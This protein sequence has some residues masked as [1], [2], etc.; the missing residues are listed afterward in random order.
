MIYKLGDLYSASNLPSPVYWA[1]ARYAQA[2][3]TYI[4]ENGFDCVICT[5]LY[6][7]EAMTAIR[8]DPDF[9]V[10]AYGV[11]TDY[12]CIP[13]IAE[14]K[15]TGYFV[16]TEGVKQQLVLKGHPAETVFV[17]GIPVSD[18]FAA[19]ADRETARQE[20]GIDPDKKVYLIM[21]GGI[22]CE[23]MMGLCDALLQGIK[24]DT[25]IYILTGKNEDLRRNLQERY[26]AC[27]QIRAIPFTRKVPLYM[28]ASDVL[29]SKPG[30]LSSTEAAV[31]NIPLVH[32]NPIPGC[33]TYNARYFA[34]TGMSLCARSKK[35][36]VAFANQLVSSKE[37]ADKMRKMQRCHINPHAA[38][39]ILHRIT[40]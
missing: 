12:T 7:M 20:L 8:Q 27:A 3:R 32:V 10:D 16:P 13:F 21:T 40:Y 2:L 24:K 14:T 37:Q 39:D 33:E 35:E 26:P 25:L 11:L 4:L 6:G 1:N 18:A 22:G 34:D 9:T 15:L 29:L 36:A 17:T 28:A 38:Q 19:H 30:G 23:N 31:A 5:H